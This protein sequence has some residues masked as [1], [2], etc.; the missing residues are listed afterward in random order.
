MF[1]MLSNIRGGGGNV[2]LYVVQT[3]SAHG[4]KS[5]A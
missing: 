3:Q 2:K 1:H 5:V 4:G